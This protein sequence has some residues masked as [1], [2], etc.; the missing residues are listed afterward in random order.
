MARETSVGGR[1][2]SDKAREIGGPY[3]EIHVNNINYMHTI[4]VHSLR[5]SLHSPVLTDA[6]C[7][8]PTLQFKTLTACH[9]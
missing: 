7:G 2:G 3:N 6:M 1:G 4:L 5:L 9:I 8:D